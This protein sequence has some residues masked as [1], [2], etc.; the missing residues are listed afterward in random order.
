MVNYKN[1]NTANKI[2]IF[3]ENNDLTAWFLTSLKRF[4]DK[5]P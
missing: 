5:K 1:E 2:K 4:F 3:N